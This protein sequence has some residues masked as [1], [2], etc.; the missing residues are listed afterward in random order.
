MECSQE[1]RI[2]EQFLYLVDS[3][4]ESLYRNLVLHGDTW[5][6]SYVLADLAIGIGRYVIIQLRAFVYKFNLTQKDASHSN[7]N[8]TRNY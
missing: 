2:E 7:F 4:D 1:V 6:V 8:L 3:V 5:G